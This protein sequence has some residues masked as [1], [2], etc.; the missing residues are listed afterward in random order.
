MSVPA[1]VS[2]DLPVLYQAVQEIALTT[3]T[4]AVCKEG[5][6][7]AS[8]CH[9]LLQMDLAGQSGVVGAVTLP[10]EI[11][12]V[13]IQV[14]VIGTTNLCPVDQIKGGEEEAAVEIEAHQVETANTGQG[15]AL[16]EIGA[17]GIAHCRLLNPVGV[18]MTSVEKR[19]RVIEDREAHTTRRKQPC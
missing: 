1:T 7:G 3:S 8:E 4:S 9:A 5:A 12:I 11:A 18:G 6:E 10:A 16:D 17:D 2:P 13:Y 15:N 19:S 14:R